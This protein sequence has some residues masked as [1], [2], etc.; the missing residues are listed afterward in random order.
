[1]IRAE[2]RGFTEDMTETMRQK[3]LEMQELLLVRIDNNEA[4]VN[5]FEMRLSAIEREL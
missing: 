1:M 3:G 5:D 2:L 4:H